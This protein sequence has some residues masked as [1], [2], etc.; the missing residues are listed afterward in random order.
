[1]PS[2]SSVLARNLKLLRKEIWS[3]LGLLPFAFIALGFEILPTFRLVGGSISA[4]DGFSLANYQTIM[5]SKFYLTSLKNSLILSLV[6]SVLGV[7]V[8]IL[9]AYALN[10]S[11]QQLRDA[12]MTFISICVNFAG[13]PLAFAFIV[14]L[15]SSG[16][17]TLLVSKLGINLYDQGFSIYTW[18]GLS[19]IYLYF[20]IPL[21]TLLIYPA[22]YGIRREWME[23][24]ANL[25][26]G[27][28]QFW[29]Y[30]G[31]PTLAPAILGTFSILMANALGAYA[32]AYALT[33]G[34]YNILP[35]RIS[36][37]ISG[38][39]SYDPGLASAAA[40]ILGLIMVLF[41]ALNQ[42]MLSRFRG[43]KA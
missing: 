13:V 19:L 22:F 35:L 9:A 4:G 11:R 24:A 17:I 43:T 6:S 18:T 3:I 34:I 21:A 15:G 2:R 26:A 1:M 33:T 14:I 42:V 36:R 25:G 8:G 12:M 29:R 10:R 40:V 27:P 41:L 38:E 23:A 31:L 7:T 37:L 5:T 20:Q 39:V 30:I 28:V 16:A 32:T